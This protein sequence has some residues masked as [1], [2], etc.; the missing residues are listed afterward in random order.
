MSNFKPQLARNID[1]EKL[2]FPC[3]VQKKWDGER[4]LIRDGEFLSRSMK[5]IR[6][7]WLK[8]RLSEIFDF[9]TGLLPKNMDGEIQIDGNFQ[10]TQGFIQSSDRE[11]DF[12]YHIFDS[13]VTLDSPFTTRHASATGCVKAIDHPQVQIVPYV[14][15]DNMEDLMAIHVE[16]VDNP[17]LDGTITR[18]ATSG[19]KCGRSTV[20]EGQ[21]MKIKEFDDDEGTITGFTERM[22]NT[23]EA[24]ENELGRTFRSSSQEGLEPTGLLAA[25]I[26]KWNGV[27]F[28][29]TATGDLP[30]REIRWKNKEEYLGK[31]VKFKYMGLTN[32]GI[33]RHPVE[34]GIRHEDDLS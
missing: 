8:A 22:H 3:L 20:K 26:V 9:T 10:A 32:D 13:T 28:K 24:Q 16:N 33:P 25:Y 30:S 6:N 14:E 27:E 17:S 18:N 31:L 2:S 34:L 19:Y 29:V 11:G 23:N 12:I 5:P 21:A 7:Q 4:L 15:V 1:L